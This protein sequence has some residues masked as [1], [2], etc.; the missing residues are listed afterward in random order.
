MKNCN[1]AGCLITVLLI[2]T[3]FDSYSQTSK[4]PP[5][6]MLRAD[7]R[8]F[9]AQELPIGKPIVLIYFSPECEECQKL[10]EELVSKIEDYWKASVAMVTYLPVNTLP[11][12]ISKYKLNIYPNIFVGTEGNAFFLR[13]YYR[14]QRFPFIAL[15]NKDGDLIKVFYNET[16]LTNVTKRLKEL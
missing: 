11:D 15:Y 13:E 2:L 3:S 14:I 10:T 16:N 7:G 5:F 12:F 6:Q 8:L 9:K 1:I 4:L